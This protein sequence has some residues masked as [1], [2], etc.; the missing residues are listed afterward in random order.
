M[1]DP[2]Y[3]EIEKELY[4]KKLALIIGQAQLCCRLSIPSSANKVQ[5][6][7]LKMA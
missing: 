5:Y 4:C 2:V 7:L 1:K 6:G 3:C